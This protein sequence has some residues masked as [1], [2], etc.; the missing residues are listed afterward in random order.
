MTGTGET[1][2]ERQLNKMDIEYLTNR[3]GPSKVSLY[4]CPE[5]TREFV[6]S[7]TM[8]DHLRTHTN[9]RVYKC[10]EENC[11][12]TFKWRSSLSQHRRSHLRSS[13]GGIAKK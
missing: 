13:K 3:V 8:K 2:M 9:E 11:G 7:S 6:K 10:G 5:C 12:K 4:A 1:M